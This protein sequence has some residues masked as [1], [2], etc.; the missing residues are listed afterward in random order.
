MRPAEPKRKLAAIVAADVVGWSRRMGVDET[1]TLSRLKKAR[2]EIF[3]PA[4]AGF[5]GR[6]F[7]T[8]GDS[9]LI[10]FPSAVAAVQCAIQI[11]SEIGDQ[12]DDEKLLFRIG[13][14]L[15]DVIVDQ[16]NVYGDGVN[17]AARLEAFSDTGGIAISDSVREQIV[18]KLE[19]VFLDAGVQKFKNIEREVRV[20]RWR[21]S[22]EQEET[23]TL[24]A[25]GLPERIRPA[26]AV[27][28]FENL[29]ADP[30][31]AYFSDGLTE[32]II[33]ALTY[34]RSFPVVARN[35][36]FAFK[37]KRND[38]R[39]VE[40]QL[41]A[42]YVLDGSVRKQGTR[43][44]AS[45][46][47]IDC[48]V[49]HTVWAGKFDRNI[50]DIFAMQDEIVQAIAAVVA[51]EMDRAELERL[52]KKTP[53]DLAAWD[54]CIRAKSLVRKRTQKETE[55]A[56]ALFEN[57]IELQPDYADAHAGLAM[58]LNVSAMK[59]FADDVQSALL[60]AV[61]SATL[62]IDI[63]P[64]SA[65]A[66]HELSTAYQLMGRAED[67]LAEARRS[68]ELNPND[69]YAIHALGNKSDLYGD[70]QGIALMEKA[71]V[72][73]Q[74]DAGSATQVSFLARAYF[75]AMALDKAVDTAKNAVRKDPTLAAAHFI[76]GLALSARGDMEDAKSAF[77]Q[78]D[79]LSPGFIASRKNWQPYRDPESNRR[80]KSAFEAVVN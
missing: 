12:Q 1:G 43:V 41:K 57:A 18:G 74:L 16:T 44:R 51:P 34:W 3:D 46:Q 29:S 38:L 48:E 28:P 70:E 68:V 71:Q 30:E 66:H 69:A 33:T 72:L 13:I 37:G 22:T 67:A 9:I 20:W 35:A 24:P 10:E 32:D 26:I 49:G 50:E 59:G 63:D 15:G 4:I 36:S 56:K 40:Q 23:D 27:L 31:N 54:I 73:C 45:A 6:V 7:N 19:D 65:W 58:T 77:T 61:K 42:R 55:T 17:V 76:L 79:E 52:S 62:A 11:Q 21:K 25:D 64:G 75:N 5:D 60:Q 47:L 53:D 14:N 8:A 2:T 39:A 78:C 80:I